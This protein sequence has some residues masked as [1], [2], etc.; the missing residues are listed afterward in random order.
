MSKQL[1]FQKCRI[2]LR[3][4]SFQESSDFYQ[5]IGLCE[6]SEGLFSDG[7]MEIE[8]RSQLQTFPALYLEPENGFK[9]PFE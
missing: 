1:Q 2:L 8:L 9:A 6:I 5:A 4:K 3:S 7:F